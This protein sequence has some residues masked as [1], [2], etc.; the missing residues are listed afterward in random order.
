MSSD[1]AIDRILESLKNIS[2]IEQVGSETLIHYVI[3]GKPD[4]PEWQKTAIT[5]GVE[6][7]L[8]YCIAYDS[9]REAYK[10]VLI[11]GAQVIIDQGHLYIPTELIA[12]EFPELVD[13]MDKVHR[14]VLQASAEG[15]FNE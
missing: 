13:L 10:T 12:R 15:A 2:G 4:V 11:K 7:F 5:D 8:P 14:I 6:V 3:S 1:E 9:E